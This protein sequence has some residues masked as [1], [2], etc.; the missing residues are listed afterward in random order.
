[1]DPKDRDSK[2]LQNVS[3]YLIYHAKFEISTAVLTKIQVLFDVMGNTNPVTKTM[4]C[5]RR[6]ESSTTYLCTW[7]HI[8][9]EVNLRQHNCENLKSHMRCS[10]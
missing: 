9:E 2:L 8:A 1:M 7:H 6:H 5:H 4:S 10:T 3:K